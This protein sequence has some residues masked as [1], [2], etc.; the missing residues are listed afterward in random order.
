MAGSLSG[1]TGYEA[2]HGPRPG[3]GSTAL[4]SPAASF[5][6]AFLSGGERVEVLER[7]GPLAARF[8]LSQIFLVSGVMKVLDPSGTSAQMESR[9]LFW[10]PFFLVAA[11]LVELGGGLSLLLG[12]KARLGALAL[13]L[14]LIPVTLTFHNFWTYPPEQQQMQMILF[15]H[16][17]TLLGGL[18]LVMTFG[19]G[20]YSIDRWRERVS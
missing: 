11:I 20:P 17:L 13:F 3:P 9:G 15:M 19:P 10:V 1:P 2:V 7:Y 6:R 16:N 8:L 5:L 4:P 18:L 12:C 14:F